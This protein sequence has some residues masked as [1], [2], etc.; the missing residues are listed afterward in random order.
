[1]RKFIAM[2]LALFCV[3]IFLA[4]EKEEESSNTVA[5]E[6]WESATGDGS[7]TG[8]WTIALKSD[9]SITIEGTWTHVNS[10]ATTTCPFSD[11]T[12]TV[13]GDS[14][15]ITVSGTANNPSAPT[16]YQNSPFEL[17]VAGNTQVGNFTGTF[18]ITFSGT[19]WPSEISGTTTATRTAG[20]GIT[21]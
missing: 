13:D 16:G 2:I 18:K 7:G 4:C 20:S 19:G 8:E 3:L 5:T 1:M 17:N 9:D 6:V 11:G 21:I 14:L 12:V 10:G 15:A